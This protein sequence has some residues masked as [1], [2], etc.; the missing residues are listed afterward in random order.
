M[1]TTRANVGCGPTPV[2]GWLNFDSSYLVSLAHHQW[3]LK[4]LQRLGVCGPQTIAASRIIASAGVQRADACKHLPVETGGLSVLYA[5][6]VI[7]HLDR[8]QAEMFLRE[9]RRALRQGG[10]IRL[11]VPDLRRRIMTYVQDGNADNFME[12]LFMRRQSI[13]SFGDKIKWLAFADVHH[14]WMYDSQSLIGLLTRN[15]F[16]DAVEVAPGVTG[17]SEPGPLDLREREDESIYVEA[18][19]V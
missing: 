7:E 8:S 13:Q 19:R 15:G 5:S 4:I 11:V 10:I 16:E 14:M 18:H 9:A 12:S 2:P 3:L 17:I 1:K 6:H